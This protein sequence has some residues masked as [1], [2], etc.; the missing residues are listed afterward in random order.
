MK[1]N[2]NLKKVFERLDQEMT[3]DHARKKYSLEYLEREI[4]KRKEVHNNN[5]MK[6]LKNQLFY[7]E[8]KSWM[9][10]GGV[11]LFFIVLYE[12]MNFFDV[13]VNDMIAF[14]MI[15]AS[16]LGVVSIVVLS[17]RFTGGI[18]EL[19]ET[20]YFSMRQLVCL[21]MMVIG[22]INVMTLTF[23]TFYTS[24]KWE[25]WLFQMIGYI[26]VPFLL[27][28]SACMGCLLSERGR[29]K[30]GY[31]IMTGV[32]ALI[33]VLLLA[34]IPRLYLV[35]SIVT[36]GIGIVAGVTIL[37]IQIQR[38]FAEINKGEILCTD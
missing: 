25:I 33:I 38:L 21:E 11:N 1:R 19:A 3:I 17:E 37:G 36:W 34:S 5:W 9:I 6:I 26:G 28:T 7:M 15:T 23:L 16:A 32:A 2:D 13:T 31:L 27:T 24:E 4:E 22:M 29:K 18:A 20:C 30:T 35:S 8:K 12:I 10:V 14:S